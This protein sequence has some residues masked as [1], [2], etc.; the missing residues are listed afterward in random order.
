MVPKL[1]RLIPNFA[2]LALVACEGQKETL[3]QERFDQ[4]NFFSGIEK[5]M[6]LADL[7]NEMSAGETDFLRSFAEDS[8]P[9][10][11]WDPSILEKAS[12]IQAPIFLL[13]GSSLGGESRSIG[14]EISESAELRALAANQFV[15][16]VADVHAH[17]ELGLL[18]FHLA[19]EINRSTSFPTLIWMSH[20]GAP[21]AWIP[22]SGISGRELGIVIKNAAAMVSKIWDESSEYAVINS[23]NDN[24]SRQD[25]FNFPNSDD[26][27]DKIS[28]SDVFKNQTRQLSALYSVGDR[29]LD[30]IGGLLPTSSLELLSLGSITNALTKEV[31]ERCRRATTEVIE[32]IIQGAL[33]DHL[34]GSY[35][36]ARRTN[37]WSLPSFSK[38][39]TSQA[40]VIHMLIQTGTITGRQDFIEEA[41]RTLQ[42]LETEWLEKSRVQ[43]SPSGDQDTPG[44]FLWNWPTLE[45]AIGRDL[46][47]FAAAAFSM[48]KDG[49]IPSEADPVG[50]FF[51]LNS[52]RSRVSIPELATQFS[53]SEDETQKTRDLIKAK[54]LD[55]REQKTVPYVESVMNCT[56]LALILRAWTAAAVVSRNPGYLEKAEILASRLSKEFI[57]PEKGLARLSL[58]SGFIPARATDYGS[59]AI[60]LSELYQVTLNHEYLALSKSLID[61]ALDKL[62][63]ENSLVSEAPAEGRVI[64]LKI[65][66]PSMI[67]SDSSLGLIDLAVTQLSGITGSPEYEGFRDKLTMITAPMAE[68]AIVNHTDF[69]STCARGDTSVIAVFQGSSTTEKGR[70]LLSQLNSKKNLP[71][72]SIRPE[73]GASPLMPLENLP[74]AATEASVVLM[75]GNEIFGQATDSEQL[76]QL[77]SK[78]LFTRD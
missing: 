21:I 31:N 27:I 74:P 25:R 66:Q 48:E 13:V 23:R 69:I 67:F 78:A 68:K 20:E 71:F 5:T 75:R 44:R 53:L 60:A 41:L 50:T 4:D 33:K 43:I 56:D 47:P 72:L 3:L 22:I 45:K 59:S 36:Y 54:L 62:K 15:C 55:Y 39:I 46:V 18:A 63:C 70:I 51:R 49:N 64:P 12:K 26:N 7:E 73:T 52:L 65:I 6:T 10:Q 58:K 40:K 37:D 24:E 61:E 28:R 9:W 30:F 8:T 38:S 57:D 2:F 17:P 29:D 32:E 76:E 14:K 35:F 77:I 34:D 16:S 11:H 1:L 42:I 19:S